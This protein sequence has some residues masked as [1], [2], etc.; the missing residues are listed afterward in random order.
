MQSSQNQS[1]EAPSVIAGEDTLTCP[2]R[3]D[4]SE[5]LIAQ[6]VTAPLCQTRQRSSYHKCWSCANRNNND[7]RSSAPK[8]K[9]AGAENSVRIESA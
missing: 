8:L 6:T 7:M 9:L 3:R 1:S 4:G 2:T 5:G